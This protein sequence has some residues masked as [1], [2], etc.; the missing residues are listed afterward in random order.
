MDMKAKSYLGLWSFK[1]TSGAHP[2]ICSYSA[3]R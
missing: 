2:L 1:I 3:S